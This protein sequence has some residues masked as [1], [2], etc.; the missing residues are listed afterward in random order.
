MGATLND[1]TVFAPQ[2]RV[3]ARVLKDQAG[4]P[5]DHILVRDHGN[6][7]DVSFE[8]DAEL[9]LAEGN[10]F[11][12]VLRCDYRPRGSCPAPAKRAFFVDDRP[13]ITLNQQQTGRTLRDLFGLT[14]A[15][16]LFRDYESPRDVF[17]ALDATADFID[18]PVFYTRRAGIGLTIVVNKQTFG[19]A[20]GVKERMTGREI[21]SLVSPEP[22]KT[23]VT[24][25]KGKARIPVGLD[26]TVEIRGCEEFSVIR[27]NVVGG[28]EPTRIQR[29]VGILRDNGGEV[30]FLESPVACAVYHRLPARRGYPYLVE[31]DVLVPIPSAYPGV[32][33]DGAYLP[34]GS[35]L[36]GR[37]E[38]SPQGQTIQA[39]GRT[40]QLVSY[41]PHN[42]GGGPPWN[43]NSASAP[44]ARKFR[45]IKANF[46]QLFTKHA[47]L[48]SHLHG[49]VEHG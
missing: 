22:D 21:A 26:E 30:T 5:A 48:G 17:I 13:E 28:F 12:T 33:L 39:L 23:E 38:G 18:G 14:P 6:E 27:T 49:E 1:T 32:M 15:V 31:T 42:G 25:D 40:W 46:S 24:R 19:E 10:V 34:T 41:H 20:D 2:Q 3:K 36:M 4:I 37:V 11:Y 43:V 45:S 44:R 8:D 9:E 35:P 16:R 7:F 29:E 47:V